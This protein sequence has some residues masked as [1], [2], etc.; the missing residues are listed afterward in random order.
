MSAAA[1]HAEHAINVRGAYLALPSLRNV[2][3]CYEGPAGT[4]KTRSILEWLHLVCKTVPHVRVLLCRKRMV[5]LTESAVVTYTDE[6]KQPWDNV[7]WFGGSRSEPPAFIYPNAAKL[8]LTGLDKPERVKSRSFNIIY[9]NEATELEEAEL[10]MLRSRVGRDDRLGFW[11]VLLDANPTFPQ[12]WLNRRMLAGRTRRMPTSH[13]DNPAY[14]DDAGTITALGESYIN[15]TLAGLTGVRRKRLLEG[16]WSQ[17]EGT[18]YEDAWLPERNLVDRRRFSSRPSDLTG[19]CGLPAEWSRYLGIDWGYRAPLA[20]QWWARRPDGDLVLYREI[21]TTMRLVEDVAREA[22]AVMGWRMTDS[23][24]LVPTH[25]HPDPLP[26]EI[27]AD[28]DAE[29]RA[30]W[31]RHFGLAVFPARKGRDSISDGIQAV[32]KRLH[33]GRLLVLR[34]SLV[35]RDPLLDERKQPQ[36]LA[37]EM[38]AYVWDVRAGRAAREVPMDEHNHAQ[39][40]ARYV[41]TYFDRQEERGGEIA[42][43]AVGY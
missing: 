25:A 3:A 31:E 14:Y 7:R 9:A 20:V 30:T 36:G 27:I 19:D 1:T 2:E 38:D 43:H 22:L 10:E 11:Q 28:H 34:D 33:A 21:Y 26:R 12:H 16:I 42:F 17:A 8:L 35:R 18:V 32:T 24:A 39:D 5:D 4:A 41:V 6:V 29:D 13:R 37:E 15:G 23:G 40:A